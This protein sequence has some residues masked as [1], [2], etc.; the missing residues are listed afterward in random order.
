[1]SICTE[2]MLLSVVLHLTTSVREMKA[3]DR[4]DRRRPGKRVQ[5]VVRAPIGMA[6]FCVEVKGL[7][8]SLSL[9]VVLSSSS[10]SPSTLNH[11]LTITL[12]STLR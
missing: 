4:E 3:R 9:I 11:P 2:M 8:V 10:S 7:F 1:V 5:M 6:S 12:H